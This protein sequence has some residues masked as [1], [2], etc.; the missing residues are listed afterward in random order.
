MF[1]P[2]SS[3]QV[4]TESEDAAFNYRLVHHPIQVNSRELVLSTDKYDWEGRTLGNFSL[5]SPKKAICKQSHYRYTQ[6]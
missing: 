3:A 6:P 5:L 4:E 2:P 1:S